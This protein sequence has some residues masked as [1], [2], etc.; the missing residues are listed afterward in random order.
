MTASRIEK[1]WLQ[2][3]VL[4]LLLYNTGAA[5]TVAGVNV[6]DRVTVGT[7][8]P[9]LVL[10]GAG[11]R[12]K[13]FIK[14]YVGALYLREKTADPAEIAAGTGAKRVTMHFLYREVSRKKIV[15][16]WSKGFTRNLSAGELEAVESRLLRFNSL[17]RTMVRGDVVHL[18]YLPSAGTEVR[19]NDE[20]Q[21]TIEG[22]DFYR[23]LLG[24]WL[25]ENPADDNLKKA[26]LATDH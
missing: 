9:E 21:G 7:D 13:L 19:I 1:I 20:H 17:F 8:G 15:D 18:D 16:A 4:M 2:S 5:M 3:M 6:P 25:G 11:I 24:V 22:E 26:M 12:K 14:V 23:A 10:N